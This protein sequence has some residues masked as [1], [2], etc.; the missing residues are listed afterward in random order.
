MR[1]PSYR[2]PQIFLTLAIEGLQ[3]LALR[4]E[5]EAS[6]LAMVNSREGTLRAS[7]LLEQ[8]EAVRQAANFYLNL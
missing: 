1:H 2:I 4:L 3:E 6:A 7:E 5:I 8:A